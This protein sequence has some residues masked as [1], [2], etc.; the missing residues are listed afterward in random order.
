MQRSFLSDCTALHYA[1]LHRHR[2]RTLTLR[3]EFRFPARGCRCDCVSKYRV[4]NFEIA[5]RIHCVV[6]SVFRIEKG[7]EG[8][9]G[10]GRFT[11]HACDR[12]YAPGCASGCDCAWEG[13]LTAC[14]GVLVCWCVCLMGHG[15]V[16]R[17]ASVQSA[18]VRR[19]CAAW[20]WKGEKWES[21]KRGAQSARKKRKKRKIQL[22]QIDIKRELF[23]DP[24]SACRVVPML[25]GRVGVY[26]DA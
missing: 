6:H 25:V 14:V 10:E 4:P 16:S 2:H 1:I 13:R 18:S 11:L 24:E 20:R 5:S 26:E 15:R 12:D 7:E 8:G 17:S 9:R 3:S 21:E 19:A 22:T 23:A